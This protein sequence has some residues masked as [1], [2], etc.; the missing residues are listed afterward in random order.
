MKADS[1]EGARD[2]EEREERR[3]FRGGQEKGRKRSGEGGRR[4]EEKLCKRGEQEE[5][6]RKDGR[7]EKQIRKRAELQMSCCLPAFSTFPLLVLP[8]ASAPFQRGNGPT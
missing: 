7:K 4:R 6:D 5:G 3:S 2:K 8:G 1:R